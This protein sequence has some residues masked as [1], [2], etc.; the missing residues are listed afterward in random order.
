MAPFLLCP[1]THTTYTHTTL[2]SIQPYGATGDKYLAKCI[3]CTESEAKRAVE[4][5]VGT[6]AQEKSQLEAIYEEKR[7]LRARTDEQSPALERVSRELGLNQASNAIGDFEKEKEAE[8]EV[9][10]K[11]LRRWYPASKL[12]SLIEEEL[13]RM[14][15]KGGS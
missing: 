9:A 11:N 14:G 5:I 8:I 6:Y 12:L 15:I 10:L 3:D 1:H 2:P 4:K 7:R 13:E